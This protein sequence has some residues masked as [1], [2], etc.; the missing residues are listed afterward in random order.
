MK[1][2]VTGAAGFI[3][4]HLV[5][6]LL[7]QGHAVFALD[8]K[9]IHEWPMFVTGAHWVRSVDV[10]RLCESWAINESRFEK[11][12]VIFHLAAESRI[13]PSFRYPMLCVNSNT[14]GTAA[15]LELARLRGCKVVYAGSSTADDDV[16]KNV[17]ALTK[18][19]GED[20][21]LTYHRCFGVPVS[22]ARFYNVYGPRQVESGR[23]A[24]VI[25]IFEKQWQ[26]G[27]K[28]TVTGMGTQRRDFTHVSDIVDGLLAMSTSE[29]FHNIISLGTGRN[30]SIEDVARMF[31]PQSQILYIPRPP[32][33]S[34]V[35]LADCRIAEHEL[36][37]KAKHR[38]E[39]YVKAVLDMK[40]TE[41]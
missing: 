26:E 39:D 15:M 19:Q 28:L 4:S 33:E 5:R 2:L 35:T 16:T 25:G 18:K 10:C 27:R 12:D 24:T 7:E 40:K 17:Y 29:T 14:T 41:E 36:G 11:I 32:G 20:L 23:Y 6:R 37:W 38:L 9:P 3:G 13:Q 21:C 22:I 8:K 31:V 34:E 30:H 1:A